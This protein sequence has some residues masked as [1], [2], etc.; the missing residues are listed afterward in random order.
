VKAN[1]V[2]ILEAYKK[3]PQGHSNKE[4]VVTGGAPPD[5]QE[6]AALSVR[7]KVNQSFG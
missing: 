4:K 5:Q 3:A 1:F 7:E 6:P 2:R